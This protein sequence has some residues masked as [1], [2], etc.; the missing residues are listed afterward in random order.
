MEANGHEVKVFD[1][2]AQKWNKVVPEGD[3]LNFK[4]SLVLSVAEISGTSFKNNAL[5]QD[6]VDQ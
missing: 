5:T 6:V 3:F 4:K 1:L 2:Y